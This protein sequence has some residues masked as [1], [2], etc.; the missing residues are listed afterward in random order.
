[1][2]TTEIGGNVSCSSICG[3]REVRAS[4]SPEGRWPWWDQKG[5]GAVWRGVR[6]RGEGARWGGPA[7]QVSGWPDRPFLCAQPLWERVAE[8]KIMALR[9]HSG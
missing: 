3:A 9:W 7:A 1:M 5:G 4:C 2:M 6:L 8:G